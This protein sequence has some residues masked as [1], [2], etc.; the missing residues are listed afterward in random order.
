MLASSEGQAHVHIN[1]S[2][3]LQIGHS[4]SG[5]A[6]EHPSEFQAHPRERVKSMIKR[7]RVA[8]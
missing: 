4:I 6:Q 5:E 2:S 8:L 7:I 1:M 3:P